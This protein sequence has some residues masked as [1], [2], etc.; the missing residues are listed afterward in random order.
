M[1]VAY[2]LQAEDLLHYQL[3]AAS[4][5]PLVRRNR[6]RSWLIATLAF[7]SL[8]VL[9]YLERITSLAV[10]FALLAGGSAALFPLYSRW[11]Y[12]RHYRKHVETHYQDQVGAPVALELTDTLLKSADRASRNELQLREL[13]QIAETPQ[14]FLLR[15]SPAGAVIV[16]KR[17]VDAAALASE[18]R[19]LATLHGIEYVDDRSWQWQ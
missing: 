17:Q 15:Y 2:A 18:L 3:Y 14:A 8:A 16:P 10:Y 11:R 1:Q 4:K 7:V 19:R 9:F 5:S 13:Y 6:R 12:K